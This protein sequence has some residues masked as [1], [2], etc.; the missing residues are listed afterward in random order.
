[1]YEMFEHTA[2][3]GVVGRGDTLAEALEWAATGMLGFMADPDRVE[4]CET[5]WLSIVATDR[6]ALAVDWLNELLFRF[7]VDGFLPTELKVEV[8]T[9]RD[10]LKALCSGE[11]YDPKRHNTLLGVK[12]ATYHELEVSQGVEWMVRVILDI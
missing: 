3:L 5:V 7:E 11:R 6:E 1:M 12:A 4:E 9:G 10:S 2:D 8:D